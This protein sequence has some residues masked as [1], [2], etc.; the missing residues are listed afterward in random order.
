MRV[1][2]AAAAA[3]GEIAPHALARDALPGRR[4]LGRHVRP[5]AL[6]LLGYHLREA[7]ERSLS[8]L[9]PRDPDHDRVVRADDHPGGDLGRAVLRPDDARAERDLQAQGEPCADRDGADDEGAASEV[10]SLGDHSLSPLYLR[11]GVN[12][13]AHLLKRAAAAD[14]GDSRVDVG[15]GWLRLV[16]QVRRHRHDHPGLAVAALGH[17]VVDPRFLHLV[18]HAAVRQALYRGDALAFGRGDGEHA[19]ADRLA[20]EV[21]RA[22]AAH[23]DAAAVLGTGEADLLPDSPEKGRVGVDVDLERSAVDRQARHG[24]SSWGG[25]EY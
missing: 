6:E 1:A 3:R 25:W 13:L 23:R 17:V 5:V 11:R 24:L 2:D 22:G 4:I 8:H 15:I 10:W 9:G 14:V 20:V 16:L 19:G 21:H 12:G 18:Q 7:G